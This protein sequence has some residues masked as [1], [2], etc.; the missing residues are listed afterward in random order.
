MILPG[1]SHTN[2]NFYHS[3]IL[4]KR[5]SLQKLK[6]IK[7]YVVNLDYINCF[8]VLLYPV[9]LT[10]CVLFDLIII[11]PGYVQ[12]LLEYQL[13]HITCINRDI[14]PYSTLPMSKTIKHESCA[15]QWFL[16]LIFKKHF[17]YAPNLVCDLPIKINL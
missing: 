3:G 13:I 6:V 4:I 9:L 10:D 8:F 14:I 7:C 5:D 2:L 16:I 11:L 12:N 17:K 15:T 1:T